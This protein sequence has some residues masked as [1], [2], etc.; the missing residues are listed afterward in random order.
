MSSICAL[1]SKDPTKPNPDP[2]EFPI[3]A[4]AS[5]AKR[6]LGSAAKDFD[7]GPFV[8]QLALSDATSKPKPQEPGLR[9]QVN[10][11]EERHRLRFF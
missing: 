2:S 1:S 8:V 6:S 9:T 11:E 5:A 10:S 3:G 4:Q 7:P